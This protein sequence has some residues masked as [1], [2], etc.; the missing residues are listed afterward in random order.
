MKILK[1]VLRN[2]SAIYKTM[3]TEEIS[4]KAK[5][6]EKMD[7]VGNELAIEAHAVVMLKK[8]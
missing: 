8:Y 6:N 4:I 1:L 3:E 7:A 2:F 5:T